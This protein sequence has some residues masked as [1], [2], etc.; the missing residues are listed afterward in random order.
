MN[1]KDNN[2][3][4]H[5]FGCELMGVNEMEFSLIKAV[6]TK[7]DGQLRMELLTWGVVWMAG[8]APKGLDS[9]QKMIWQMALQDDV[10]SRTNFCGGCERLCHW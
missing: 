7:A 8:N 2:P 5:V 9:S 4:T 6:S 3:Y 1:F 10:N